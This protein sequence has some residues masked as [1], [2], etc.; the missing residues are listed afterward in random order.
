[1]NLNIDQELYNS[2]PF[3]RHLIDQTF[4]YE[5]KCQELQNQK[6]KLRQEMIDYANQIPF[7]TMMQPQPIPGIHRI[8]R[9]KTT[10]QTIG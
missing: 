9:S 8:R 6:E 2:N 1:M 5:R 7:H 4:E 10:M 3:Y